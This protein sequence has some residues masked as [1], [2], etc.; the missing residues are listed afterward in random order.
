MFWHANKK[1]WM[2][3]AIFE[4]W[5]QNCLVQEVETYLAKKNLHFKIVLLLDNTPGHSSRNITFNHPSVKVMFL[6]PNTTSILQPMD[7]GVIR[8][9]NSHYTR[10]VYDR[11]IKGIDSSVTLIMLDSWKAYN[12]RDGIEVIKEAW[13]CVT[14][15]TLNS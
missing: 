14:T 3:A 11:A 13:D 1:A 6:P 8:S 7:C 5:F 15:T 9:F 4:D 10:H 2:T 12:I